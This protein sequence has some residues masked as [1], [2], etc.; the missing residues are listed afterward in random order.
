[1]PQDI[2]EIVNEV[3]DVAIKNDKKNRHLNSFVDYVELFVI[4]ICI[5]ILFFSILFR[6][7]TVDGDSMNMTLS[8]GETLL[9]SDL[10]YTPKRQDVIVFHNNDTTPYSQHNKPLVKRVIGIE[11]DTVIIDYSLNKITVITKANETIVLDEQYLY[12]DPSLSDPAISTSTYVVPEGTVFVL[13]DNRRNSLD[14]R[15]SS[16]GFVDERS[17]LGK[18]Y[19]RVAPLSRFGTVK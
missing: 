15:Y 14:S 19:F 10:F 8:D 4:A 2:N 7:C 18:V 11:G 9:V 5:V 1:M 12:L 3:D 17:I 13:G 6:T 16:V